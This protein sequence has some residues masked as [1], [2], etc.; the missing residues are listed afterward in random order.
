MALH[1]DTWYIQQITFYQ[2]KMVTKNSMINNRI[3]SMAAKRW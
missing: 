2:M 3:S 1:E